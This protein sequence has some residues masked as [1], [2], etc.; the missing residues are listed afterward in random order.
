MV[1]AISYV[2]GCMDDYGNEILEQGGY[3]SSL[4]HCPFCD[5]EQTPEYY[6]GGTWRYTCPKCGSSIEEN[7]YE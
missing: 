3:M 6:G 4:S 7:K 1:Y 5:I 2:Y